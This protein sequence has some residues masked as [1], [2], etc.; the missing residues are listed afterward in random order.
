MARDLLIS[1]AVGVVI[2]GFIALGRPDV[3]RPRFLASGALIG[4]C[5]ALACNLLM[6]GLRSILDGL[7]GGWRRL[8]TATVLFVGGVIGWCVAAW[9]GQIALGV[10]MFGSASG[11][12]LGL[13]VMGL[14]A[15]GVGSLFVLYEALRSRLERSIEEAKANEYAVRELEL[16]A[17]LQ[18]R[19]L[20]ERRNSGRGW[21]TDVAHHPARWVAGD[22][23]HVVRLPDG[24]VVAAVGDVAGKG[25][26]ASL[27]MASVTARLPLLLTD[28]SLPETFEE[29][30][31][32]LVEEGGV[33]HFVALALVRLD[34]ASGAFELANAGLPDPYHLC[35]DGSIVALSV[36][37]PR[38]PLGVRAGSG[39]R[40]LRGVL[41]V[42][43]RLLLL[44]DGIPEATSPLGEPL[45]YTAF[46][47]LLGA[48]TARGPEGLEDL[49]DEVRR[50]TG[51]EPED[52]WTLMLLER[53]AVEPPDGG[54]PTGSE[55]ATVGVGGRLA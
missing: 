13:L 15:V 8:A 19:L 46:E 6:R 40:V 18:S 5:I 38:L 11:L 24:S 36:P 12:L 32:R 34:P 2:I 47:R 35:A 48:A 7:A 10:R 52:D 44:S 55:A 37:G 14:V 50:R 21:R 9:I 25:M 41:A 53:T 28:H 27:V 20:P 17:V 45:G 31:R 22:L 1:A 26:A 42:G 39:Y 51:S 43:E 29:L 30:G 4:A 54:D 16:A 33:R 23:Y 3:L 49:V